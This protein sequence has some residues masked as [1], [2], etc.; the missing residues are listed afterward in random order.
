MALAEVHRSRDWN[1]SGAEDAYRCALMFNPNNEG[2][3]RLYGVF[4]S[5]Q[6]QTGA[7]ATM[8][9]RA[10]ELDPLCLVTNTS[11]AWVRYVDGHYDD[12][13][14]RCRHT[15][16]MDAGFLAPHRLLAAARLQM[17]D[18]GG[19]IQYLDSVPAIL[20]DPTSLA[21]LAHALG[22]NGDRDRAARILSTLNDWARD[23]YVSPYHRAIGHAGLE[24]FDATFALLSRACDDRDPAL[25]H[26]AS[27]PRFDAIRRD[28]RYAAVIGRIGVDR[29]SAV[30]A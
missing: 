2:A 10:C 9:D 28:A 7:A 26:L 11:A 16:D 12:V 22:V 21:W 24:D 27:E 8:T 19:S 15:I 3:R 14:E 5:A 6:R 29:E 25:M 13:V 23:R 17:G 18:V 20:R 30:H 4:L 1:W